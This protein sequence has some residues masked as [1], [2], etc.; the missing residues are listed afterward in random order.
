[1]TEEGREST[2]ESC[3][4]QTVLCSCY[5]LEVNACILKFSHY[6]LLCLEWKRQHQVWLN[7]KGPRS[8][9]YVRLAIEKLLI[10]GKLCI[11]QHTLLQKM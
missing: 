8:E 4:S 6:C 5:M 9:L 10:K 11:H 3:L 2:V 7:C 1:M